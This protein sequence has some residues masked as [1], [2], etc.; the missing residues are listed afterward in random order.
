M[1]KEEIKEEEKPVK[2]DLACG[3]K[4]TPGTI[5][6]DSKKTPSVDVVHNLTKFPYP[7]KDNSVD[8]IYCNHYVE[9]TE[10][11]ISFI[12]ECW[13]ILK[14][15]GKMYITAPYYSSIRAWQDPTHKRAISEATFLYFNKQWR[16]QNELKHYGIKSDFDF[17]Y[18]YAIAPEWAN[19]SDEDRAFAICYYIN[20][21]S[22]IH[23]TL[24]KKQPS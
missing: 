13:R 19:R 20:V 12:D 6:V 22:D 4:K 14:P 2:L 1:G 8:E 21:V 10:D 23:I 7:W 24:I 5:G 11:L 18:G 17:T 9:H 16:E 15:E 3:N